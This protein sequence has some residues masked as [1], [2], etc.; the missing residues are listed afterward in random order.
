MFGSFAVYVGEKIVFALR[1]RHDWK[2]DNGVWIATTPEHHGSLREELPGMRSIALFGVDQ[3]GWQVLPADDDRFEK[4]VYRACELIHEGDPR[5][6][7]IP[8]KRK[9]NG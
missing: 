3:T 5:I 9:K 2:Q 8:K 6:G 1:D 7:K 4:M